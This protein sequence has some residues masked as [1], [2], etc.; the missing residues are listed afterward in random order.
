MFFFGA[1]HD[2]RQKEGLFRMLLERRYLP[3]R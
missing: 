3:F 2:Q 1:G